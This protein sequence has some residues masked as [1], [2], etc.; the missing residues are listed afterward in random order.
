MQNASPS[1]DSPAQP[2]LDDTTAQS[3]EEPSLRADLALLVAE[4]ER[5]TAGSAELDARIHVG[6]RVA[7]QGA[8]DMAALL[9]REG[10]TWPTVHDAINEAIPPYTTS[11]DAAL[12]GEDISFVVRSARRQRWGA[13]QMAACG[14]EVLAWAA[15]EPLARRLAAIRAHCIDLE[16]AAATS[17]NG[18]AEPANLDHA[19]DPP[20]ADD[21]EVMF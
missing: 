6:Y 15:T 21:W 1:V 13:M 20:P 3:P 10:V 4:I 12:A 11:L 7:A 2:A 18:V 19:V 5:A 9:I 16:K 8:P 17:Q 14:E